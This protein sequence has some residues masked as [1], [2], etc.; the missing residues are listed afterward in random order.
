MFKRDTGKQFDMFKSASHHLSKGSQ[1][2]LN[3]RSSWNT[4]FRDHFVSQIDESLYS[5]LYS[6]KMGRPNASIRTLIGMMMLK[7]MQGWSDEQLFDECMFNLRV[8]SALGLLHLDE[9][10]P[11]ASTYYEFRSK[12]AHYYETTGE[13]LMK[14][15]FAQVSSEQLSNLSISGS[16]IR[17]DS[18]LIQSNIARHNRLQLIVESVR[19]NIQHID[20]EKIQSHI[21]ET[22][23][24]YLKQ[25][26]EKSTSNLTYQLS[27]EEKEAM[28]IDFGHILLALYKTKIIDEQSI[29]YKI[30]TEQYDFEIGED[31]QDDELHPQDPTQI[32]SDSIQSIHDIEAAYRKKGKDQNVQMV[33]GYHSNITETCDEENE[34]N[35]ITDVITAPANVNEDQFLQPALQNTQEN[36][37]T[38]N[39]IK[40]VITDG[41]YDSIDNRKEMQKETAPAWKMN[42]L[43]GRNRTYEMHYDDEEQLHVI[44]IKTG[45]DCEVYWSEK[46]Q[47]YRI[48]KD[49]GQTIYQTK[50]QVDNYIACL[51]ILKQSTEEDYNLRSSAESTIHQVFHRLWRR[52]KTRYRGLLK[53][54]W[55]V[56]MRALSVNISRITAYFGIK[57]PKTTIL[58]FL[59][60]I[61]QHRS[62]REYTIFKSSIQYAI[63]F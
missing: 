48:R 62:I 52:Q 24:G 50:E 18:K 41:G 40:Q 59:A 17:M 19:V 53:H 46:A 9:Q 23:Y 27:K 20:L 36:L 31:N 61:M 45:Q 3:N 44:D 57:E 35:L 37:G 51:K 39:P 4:V 14:K 28:L 11:C 26:V 5:V 58:M 56:L 54:H 22:Q 16:K 2:I 30:L 34:I 8:R 49:N 15:T 32:S 6:E 33:Q 10:V 12:L 13:D 63:I 55:Y 25:L 43:K 1:K 29:M 47:K 60:F 38:D 42:K 7:E 21:N